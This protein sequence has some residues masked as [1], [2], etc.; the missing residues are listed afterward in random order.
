MRKDEQ[1]INYPNISVAKNQLKWKSKISILEGLDK[2]IQYFK[3][4]NKLNNYD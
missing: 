4:N 1:L 3:K 2:T